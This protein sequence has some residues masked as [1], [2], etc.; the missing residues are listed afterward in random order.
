MSIVIIFVLSTF[1]LYYLIKTEDTFSN[2]EALIYGTITILITLFVQFTVEPKV[3]P[4][5]YNET[6]EELAKYLSF[7]LFLFLNK[8]G[9]PR[10]RILNGAMLGFSFAT[11]ETFV[12]LMQGASITTIIFRC[13]FTASL[14]IGLG[15]IMAYYII[16]RRNVI[17]F[18]AILIPIL[19]HVA[20]NWAVDAGNIIYVSIITLSIVILAFDKLSKSESNYLKSYK[21]IS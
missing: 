16:L 3:K 9:I 19:L 18:R 17:S 4:F 15:V 20:F 7:S 8:N 12:I 5:G 10:I 13:I 1:F 11:I 2:R 21:A 14:H 6:I